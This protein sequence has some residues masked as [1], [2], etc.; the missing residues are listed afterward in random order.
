M[1]RTG[2]MT[3][4]CFHCYPRLGISDDVELRAQSGCGAQSCRPFV[5]Q[6]VFLDIMYD[7]FQRY[8]TAPLLSLVN[9]LP[10]GPNHITHN[11]T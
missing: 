5:W 3:R 1:C 7:P 2:V 9:P 8:C 4:H 11:V 10:L 6:D